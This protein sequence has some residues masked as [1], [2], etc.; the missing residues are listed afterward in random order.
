MD[1][2]DFS[3]SSIRGAEISRTR[4]EDADF[5]GVDFSNSNMFGSAWPVSAPS[6]SVLRLSCARRG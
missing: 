1:G 3:R 5:R 4:A 2:A 6:P